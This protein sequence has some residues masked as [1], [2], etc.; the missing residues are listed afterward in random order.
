MYLYHSLKPLSYREKYINDCGNRILIF[1]SVSAVIKGFII[2][3][4]CGLRCASA[5][6]SI[7]LSMQ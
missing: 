5:E 3:G 4:R 1:A 6:W 7:V 2:D